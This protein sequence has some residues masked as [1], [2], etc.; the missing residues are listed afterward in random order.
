MAQVDKG[1]DLEQVRQALQEHPVTRQYLFQVLVSDDV[2]V[3]DPMLA[4]WGWFTRFDP[5][6]DIHPAHRELAGNRI[7]FQPPITI[8]ATWKEGYRLPVAFDPDQQAKV[9]AKWD[10]YGIPGE[11][12]EP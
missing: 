8:D 11:R 5:L 2:P 6:A 9:K 7:L 10:R 3:E 1:A 12:Y 4:L